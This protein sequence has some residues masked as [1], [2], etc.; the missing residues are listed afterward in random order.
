MVAVI[1]AEELVNLIRVDIVDRPIV[2]GDI[3]HLHVVIPSAIRGVV[4]L[5]EG[6]CPFPMRKLTPLGSTDPSVA[7]VW[8]LKCVSVGA[9]GTLLAVTVQPKGSAHGSTWRHFHVSIPA[10]RVG[11][12]VP[13]KVQARKDAL[14]GQVMGKIAGITVAALP[15]LEEFLANSH[16]V[17]I[18]DISAMRALQART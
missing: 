3:I 12:A 8:A 5:S 18:V 17:G 10:V 4:G 14:G 11:A 2:A 15:L 7:E 13:C 16:L 6:A 9:F 1:W